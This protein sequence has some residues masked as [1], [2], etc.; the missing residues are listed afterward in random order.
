MFEERE[1]ATFL[2][3]P[4]GGVEIIYKESATLTDSTE[5]SEA[6]VNAQ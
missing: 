5:A 4:S 3:S 2:N 6:T 1:T